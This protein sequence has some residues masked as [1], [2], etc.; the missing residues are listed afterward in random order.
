[1][2]DNIQYCYHQIEEAMDVLEALLLAY[3][4]TFSAIH[5]L[6]TLTKHDEINPP[7]SLDV[8]NDLE[9]TIP[10]IMAI[11]RDYFSIDTGDT[12]SN[13]PTKVSSTKITRKFPGVVV[14]P[15]PPEE[16]SLVI[17]EVNLAKA[18]FDVAYRE[19]STDSYE[20][21][22]M[23]HDLYPRLVSSQ[24]TRQL[25]HIPE[26]IR[27]L[28][29][30][31]HVPQVTKKVTKDEVISN[32]KNQL[33]KLDRRMMS[34]NEHQ[35]AVT[36]LNGELAEIE[37]VGEKDLLK[38]IRN[39]GFPSPAANISILTKEMERVGKNFKAPMPFFVSNLPDLS[40]VTFL[41]SYVF[42]TRKPAITP[43]DS[44]SFVIERIGLVKT[45]KKE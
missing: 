1:M 31:W 14:V 26:L 15:A 34:L 33:E 38:R 29:F 12:D 36:L 21:F 20:R 23:L 22:S 30:Y 7:E 44:Y 4:P 6:P 40:K 37:K 2:S 27:K 19:L 9:L 10:R 17:A 39:S 13:N 8:V 18:K 11:L 43:P 28:S 25:V 24:I 32:L 3:P 16:L 42:P 41:Q 5:R 35:E 45:K